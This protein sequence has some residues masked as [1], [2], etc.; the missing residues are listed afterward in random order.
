[1][2]LKKLEQTTT[3]NYVYNR[4][5][6][7]PQLNCSRCHPHRGCNRKWFVSRSWKDQIKKRK[8]WM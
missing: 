6:I 4:V 2:K 3:S 1:M 7:L 5:A 8:Q